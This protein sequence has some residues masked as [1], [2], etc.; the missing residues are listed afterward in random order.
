MT[1]TNNLDAAVIDAN[2]LIA[3]CSKEKSKGQTAETHFQNYAKQGVEF[4]APSIIIG[5]VMYILC[6]KLKDSSLTQAEYEQAIES[7]KDYMSIISPTPNGEASLISRA[8]EIRQN[9]GCS[10]SADSFYI[11][12]AEELGKNLTVEI[13]TFDKGFTNQIAKNAPTVSV[14]ILP[15]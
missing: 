15:L 2:I 7:F 14:N 5:E 9:Y 4:Y 13:L 3:I 12:L 1:P 6:Q 11:A 10:H 8:D